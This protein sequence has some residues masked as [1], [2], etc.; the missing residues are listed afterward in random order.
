MA[1]P[2]FGK[3]GDSQSSEVRHAQSLCD[4]DSAHRARALDDKIRALTGGPRGNEKIV[5]PLSELRNAIKSERGQYQGCRRGRREKGRTL[6]SP[7]LMNE[8]VNMPFSMQIRMLRKE[9]QIK[10]DQH[11]A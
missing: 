2:H 4:M 10:R 1:E 3:H 7:S 8:T 11:V 6:L 9:K 5:D